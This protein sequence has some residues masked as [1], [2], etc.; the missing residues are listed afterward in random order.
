MGVQE[1]N[2]DIVSLETAPGSSALGLHP[3]LQ[4]PVVS[5]RLL[6][7]LLTYQ[8]QIGGSHNLP[9]EFN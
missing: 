7:V 4:M 6:P 2:S 3:I 1:L 5:H 8:L 9:L